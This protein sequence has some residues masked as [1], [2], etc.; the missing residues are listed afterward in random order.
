[1]A[2][3]EKRRQWNNRL[4]LLDGEAVADAADGLQP[5]RVGRIALDLA[6][7]AVDLDVDRTLADIGLA[8][9]QLVAGNGLAG[10]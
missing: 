5:D 1:M 2:F 4:A 9:D 6:P 8:G 10:P 3:H 7:Q